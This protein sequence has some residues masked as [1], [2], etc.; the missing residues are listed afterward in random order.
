MMD[1]NCTKTGWAA[2]TARRRA[3]TLSRRG[4]SRPGVGKGRQEDENRIGVAPTPRTRSQPPVS[5]RSYAVG[6]R[7]RQCSAMGDRRRVGRARGAHHHSDRW[8]PRAR[9]T[10]HRNQRRNSYPYLP[11][12]TRPIPDHS[13]TSGGWEI[14]VRTRLSAQPWIL[15]GMGRRSAG[16]GA[17]RPAMPATVR[18][19]RNRRC[20]GRRASSCWPGRASCS[21]SARSAPCRRARR[22]RPRR[23]ARCR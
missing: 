14:G 1:C 22:D 23:P 9:P 8:A 17:A 13:G 21:R 6:G 18:W 3:C 5:F 11:S 7:D 2:P 19:V 12:P 10:L 20:S 16:I 4:I 15:Q